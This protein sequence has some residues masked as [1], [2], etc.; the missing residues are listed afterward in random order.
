MCL[1]IVVT[2]AGAPGNS[3]ADGVA[4]VQ[5]VEKVAAKE[6][7]VLQSVKDVLLGLVADDAVH[8][9][10]IGASKY[11]WSFPS[12]HAIKARGR[13]RDLLFCAAS[14]CVLST[15]PQDSRQSARI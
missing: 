13:V 5:D 7:V 6:G 11:Y 3:N 15:A 8:E 12:E 14:Y 2:L 9:E 10:R 1:G 4:P